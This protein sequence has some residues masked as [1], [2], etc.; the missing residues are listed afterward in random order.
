MRP[1]EAV[2]QSVP[3]TDNDADAVRLGVPP[4]LIAAQKEIEQLLRVAEV[5]ANPAAFRTKDRLGDH[6]NILGT[7]IG[8]KE[9]NGN[10][11]SL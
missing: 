4:G 2:G 7:A 11:S 6:T 8:L 5:A 3:G 10:L 9:V 1:S